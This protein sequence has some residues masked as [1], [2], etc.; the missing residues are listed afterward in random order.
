MTEIERSKETYRQ[1]LE[2]HYLELYDYVQ[3]LPPDEFDPHEPDWEWPKDDEL[4][5]YVGDIA[6]E[7]DVR[8]QAYG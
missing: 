8:E 7:P 4:D 1:R 6:A 3:H 2:Q 5:E